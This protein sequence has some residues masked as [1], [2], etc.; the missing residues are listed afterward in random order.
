MTTTTDTH[1]E[2]HASSDQKAVHR[3]SEVVAVEVADSVAALV[4]EVRQAVAPAE[5]GRS[6]GCYN[7]DLSETGPA[8]RDRDET[9]LPI[10]LSDRGLSVVSHMGHGA[11]KT[12]VDSRRRYGE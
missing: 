8:L 1:I 5:A 11:G 7:G 12:T 9:S 2:H 10:P 6:L 3:A 4:E